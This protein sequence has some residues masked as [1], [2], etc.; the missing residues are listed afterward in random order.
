MPLLLPSASLYSAW[1]L[2]S[3]NFSFETRL[4]A[5]GAF[6][7]TPSATDQFCSVSPVCGRNAS[8]VCVLPPKSSTGVP[9]LCA[10]LASDFGHFGGRTPT[11]LIVRCFCCSVTTWLPT[12]L[13]PC[14][15]ARNSVPG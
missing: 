15:V 10:A 7:A 9:N 5:G 1:I 12:S 2:K 13:S 6:V 14:R 11:Q 3:L 8:R 4:L